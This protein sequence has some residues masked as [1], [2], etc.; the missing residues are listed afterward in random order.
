[1]TTDNKTLA[2]A[3]PGGR[4]RLGDQAE[5]ARFEAWAEGNNYEMEWTGLRYVE[6]AT[7][8]AWLAWQAALAAQ[9]SPGGQDARERE[10]WRKMQKAAASQTRK[11]GVGACDAL[12]ELAVKHGASD[13]EAAGFAHHVNG[14]LALLESQVHDGLHREATMESALAARQPVGEPVAWLLIS[15]AGTAIGATRHARERE[16]W[17]AAGGTTEPLYATPRV[18]DVDGY[19][20]AFYE[21]ADMLSM[22]AQPCPPKEVWETQ[23]RPALQAAISAQ[24]PV[25]MVLHCPRCRLQHIDAP[26]ERTPDWQNPPHRSHLCHGCGLIWR[27][28]DVPTIGVERTQTTG[29]SDAPFTQP[30]DAVDPGRA[31]GESNPLLATARRNIR[32]FLS[33]ASFKSEADRW[34]AG[35]CIDVLEAAIDAELSG[36]KP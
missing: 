33:N 35:Q 3:Q 34:S 36:V 7:H 4:V 19:R 11:D 25:P 27:P 17:E 20:A 31:R 22:T 14:S 18:Q 16:S 29:K 6:E 28:A 24:G 15:E 23:M 8:D 12:Y 2:D 5:R 13:R 26:D 30:G 10:G 1:M 9:P 32:K 21:L